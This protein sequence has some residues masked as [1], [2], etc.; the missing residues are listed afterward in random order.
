MTQKWT[1]VIALAA[2]F[3]GGAISNRFSLVP[4]HAQNSNASPKEIRAQSFVLVDPSDRALGTFTVEP[5]V[6]QYVKGRPVV[7]PHVVLRDSEGRE[8]WRAG[9]SAIRPLMSER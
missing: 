2:G 5:L 1:L 4:V 3:V 8:I 6:P 7:E 9:G